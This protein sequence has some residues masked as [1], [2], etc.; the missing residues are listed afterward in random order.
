M[1][2][3]CAVAEAR[4]VV[5]ERAPTVKVVDASGR[6]RALP[7]ARIPVVVFYEDKDAAKQN[8]RAR[9]VVGTFTDVKANR[10]LFDF[11]PVADVEKWNWWPARR[12]VLSEV[13][14]AERDAEFPIFL[15]WRG[16]VRKQWG[17]TRGKSG[18]LLLGSD[19][20]VLFAAEGTLGEEQLKE[21]AA[22][23]REIVAR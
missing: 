19:G 1:S 20:K 13:R 9:E 10:K 22:R 3:V 15:D 7:D 11:V 17:L 16:D 6:E 5:G 14:D 8:A 21:I 12:Y 4:P 23:L 18:V 2:L